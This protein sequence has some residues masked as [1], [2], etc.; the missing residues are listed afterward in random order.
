MDKE[1]EDILNAKEIDPTTAL[2]ILISVS[3]VSFDKDHLNDADRML[4]TKALTCFKKKIDNGKNFL[5][6]VK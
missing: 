3:Q 2:N 5:I 4:I 1:M 6:R